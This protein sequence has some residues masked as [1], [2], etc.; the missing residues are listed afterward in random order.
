MNKN[1]KARVS[2][3]EIK[4]DAQ[5]LSSSAQ[6]CEYRT[7]F[8]TNICVMLPHGRNFLCLAAEIIASE[9]MWFG[10]GGKVFTADSLKVDTEL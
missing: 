1:K 5:E 3:V 6:E 8:C 4:A 9:V 7:L 10:R 2:S